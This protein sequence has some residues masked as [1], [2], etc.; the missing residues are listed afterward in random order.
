[1]R[2]VRLVGQ[3]DIKLCWAGELELAQP[4][5]ML[6]LPRRGDCSGNGCSEVYASRWKMTMG[7]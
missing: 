4:A 5:W 2:L 3:E 7:D 6:V 1:V